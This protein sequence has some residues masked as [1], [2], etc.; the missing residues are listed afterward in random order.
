[1]SAARASL[2][3][4]FRSAVDDHLA[5]VGLG[6]LHGLDAAPL[7]K[8]L[9]QRRL[10]QVLRLVDVAHQQVRRP[11]QRHHL[12]LSELLEG[13]RVACVHPTSSTDVIWAHQPKR[14]LAAEG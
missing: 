4:A 7:A 11:E 10:E 1:V 9:L 13:A 2:A 14:G 3:S 6:M 8:G 12:A 5:N